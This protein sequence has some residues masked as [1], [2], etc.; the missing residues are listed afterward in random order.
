MVRQGRDP[1]KERAM[2]TMRKVE[3]ESAGDIIR[4]LK[5]AGYDVKTRRDPSVKG[6]KV[7]I[8]GHTWSRDAL[9]CEAERIARSWG[10]IGIT[11]L[12]AI[13]RGVTPDI[14]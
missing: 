1:S 7:R 10:T 4:E 12:A 5:D 2:E 6:D 14:G 13:A 11:Q 3:I 8:E 9:K